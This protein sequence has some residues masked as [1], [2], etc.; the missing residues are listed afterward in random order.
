MKRSCLTHLIKSLTSADHCPAG[1]VKNSQTVMAA[2]KKTTKNNRHKVKLRIL[3]VNILDI[4]LDVLKRCRAR[5]ITEGGSKQ[6]CV[7]CALPLL[8]ETGATGRGRRRAEV[9]AYGRRSYLPDGHSGP[10]CC[11]HAWQ[12]FQVIAH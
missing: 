11:D 3:Y 12:I 7:S 8:C 4:N 2:L 6:E 5:N 10:F 1:L 9:C